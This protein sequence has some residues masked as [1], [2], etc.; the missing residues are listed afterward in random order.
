VPIR[1]EITIT[2]GHEDWYLEA[3]GDITESP[4]DFIERLEEALESG[5]LD[6]HQ[7]RELLADYNRRTR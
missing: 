7:V 6:I 1:L 5:E 4:E 2:F 3:K